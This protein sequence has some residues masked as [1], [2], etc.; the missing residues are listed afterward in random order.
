MSMELK[1]VTKNS[2]TSKTY[3]YSTNVIIKEITAGIGV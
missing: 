3:L 1:C 2:L